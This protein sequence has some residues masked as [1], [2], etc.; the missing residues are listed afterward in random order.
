MVNLTTYMQDFITIVT[1]RSRLVDD[2]DDDLLSQ[3][4]HRPQKLKSQFQREDSKNSS[5]VAY[6]CLVI[7]PSD[8]ITRK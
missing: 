3:H 1:Q 6:F 4:N 2:D 5:T 8:H 7:F